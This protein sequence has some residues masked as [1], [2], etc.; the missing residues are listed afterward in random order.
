MRVQE[1]YTPQ[2]MAA[3]ATFILAGP[4][5]SGFIAVAAGAITITDSKGKTILSALPVTAGSYVK[6]NIFWPDLLNG[7]VTLSGGASGTLLI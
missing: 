4:C 5:V 7:T 6:L 2:P 1:S 3:N